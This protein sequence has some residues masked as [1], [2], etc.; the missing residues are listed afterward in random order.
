MR[1]AND[2]RQV[3]R[4]ASLPRQFGG[5]N[6]G[7]QYP[8]AAPDGVGA[9]VCNS[10]P[11]AKLRMPPEHSSGCFLHFPRTQTTRADP[12]T[13]GTASCLHAHALQVRV[14]AAIR[15]VVGVADIVA[16]ARS[17]ATDVTALSHGSFLSRLQQCLAY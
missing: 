16:V 11:E 5:T 1:R 6:C 2:P 17:L 9:E 4:P 14:P 8:G 3:L 15:E 7:T 12:H 10:M 13:F